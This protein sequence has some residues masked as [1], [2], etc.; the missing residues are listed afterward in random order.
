MV[1]RNGVPGTAMP[2]FDLLPDAQIESLVEYVKYLSMRGETEI[3]LI[4]AMAD[5]SEGAQL[6]QTR[7]VLVDEILKP[8]VETWTAAGDAIIQPVKKPDIRAG[9]IDRGGPQ[10][11][12]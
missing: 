2:S 7:A 11:L 4:A 12:L 5:L 10:D 6:E 1:L 8:V 9:R 3:R